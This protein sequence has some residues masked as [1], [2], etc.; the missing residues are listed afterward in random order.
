[1]DNVSIRTAR[2]DKA[3]AEPQRHGEQESSDAPICFPTPCKEGTWYML[4][5][6]ASDSQLER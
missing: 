3:G 6:P 5:I 4:T 2:E 1:M